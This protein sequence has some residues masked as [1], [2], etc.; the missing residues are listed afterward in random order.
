MLLYVKNIDDWTVASTS[1]VRAA[2]GM[3]KDARLS[4]VGNDSSVLLFLSL[5]VTMKEL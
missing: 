3:V 5:N 2:I 1:M 4:L